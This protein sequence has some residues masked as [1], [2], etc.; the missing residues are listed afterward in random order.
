[1]KLIVGLGNP[2]EKYLL[3]RH[4]VGFMA[5][6]RFASDIGVGPF[7]QEHKALV[8]KVKTPAYQA[9]L[10]KPQ[11]FMNLSGQSVVALMSYYGI[12]PENLLVLHDEVDLPFGSIRYQTNRGHGGHNGIRNIH[13]LLGNSKYDRLKL[14]VGRPIHSKMAVSDFVLSPFNQQEQAELPDWLDKITDSL[15]CYLEQGYQKAA[16]QFNFT[17]EISKDSL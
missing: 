10:A 11:T 16:T 13:Q 12:E 3:T 4:N 8:C 2:G 14:G 1:M 5:I 7:K 9:V 6:D 17:P 15:Y